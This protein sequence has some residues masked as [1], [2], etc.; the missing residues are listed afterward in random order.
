MRGNTDIACLAGLVAVLSTACLQACTGQPPGGPGGIAQ[1][2]A[3]S[4]ERD[5]LIR[6]MYFESNRSSR[7]GLMAVG[8][9]V[10]NRVASPLY[11]NTICGVVGQPGQFAAGVLTRPLNERELPPV[12]RA[13]DAIRA[14]ERYKP[15]GNAMHFHVAG[16][17]IPYQVRYVAMAGGNTFY[18]K[19]DRQRG[20]LVIA[21][22]PSTTDVNV[23]ASASKPKATLADAAP[24]KPGVMQWLYAAFA[25]AKPAKSC[26]Q[27]ATAFGATSLACEDERAAR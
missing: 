12:Q 1:I 15:I 22:G 26:E 9:V 16:L 18:L 11:P 23:A 27:T 20:D 10:M 8:T 19:T 21:G 7:E 24:P 14:G 25:E 5:C 17:A 13:A 2:A 4:G 6:A 3:K